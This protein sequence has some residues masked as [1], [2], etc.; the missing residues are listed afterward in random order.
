MKLVKKPE[1]DALF[2]NPPSHVLGVLIYGKDRSQVIERATVLAKRIVP[3]IT[4]PFN[5]S[6]ITDTDIEND[7]A[8]LEGEL[9][10]L[11]MMGGRRLVRL[12]FFT[13]K[14]AL[15]KAVA[16]VVKQHAAGD[17]NREAFLIIEAGSLGGESALRRLADADKALVS[18]ACYEDETGDIIRMAREAFAANGVSLT[19]GAMDIFA[20]RL[21]KERGIAH[22]EIE[23][24]ILFIGPHSHKT[25]EERELQDFLGVEPE[26]S[27]FKAAQDAF[28]GRMKSAQ[29]GLRRAFAEGETGPDAMRALSGHYNKV[30]LLKTNMSKGMGGKE[31]A[32]V[33]GV[34][35]KDEADMLRQAQTWSFDLLD[36]LASDLIEAD[37]QCKSTGMPDLLIA[38]R[39]YLQIAGK[40]NRAGL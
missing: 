5:V 14:A 7:P 10:S 11:S 22:Q 4:D 29:A 20:Q 2:K 12:K 18:I 26:A 36:P 1:I 8:R 37:K 15:D 32:K 39:L 24:L 21:P 38:E 6:L 17:Y 27:L 23:R 40:A 3:D 31:A 13:E 9:Q 25:L 28:G 30:K 19:T 33:S 34:F 16:A 35:W